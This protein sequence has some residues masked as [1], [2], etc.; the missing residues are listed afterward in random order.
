MN[1]IAP[2]KHHFTSFHSSV[3]VSPK[4]PLEVLGGRFG[5]F[6]IELMAGGEAA[7]ARDAQHPRGASHLP[8]LYSHISINEEPYKLPATL[9]IS[10]L[11]PFS[12]FLKNTDKTNIL[13]ANNK[14]TAHV[15][16][17]SVRLMCGKYGLDKVGFLTLTFAD[18]ILDPMEAQ[19]RLNS[20]L[21][22]IIKPR[23]QDYLGVMERQKSGRIHYHFLVALDV[24]IRTG[25]N[26]D[27]ASNGVYKSASNYLR[28]EWAF[29]RGTSK[30][31]GFGR[32]ELM[33]IKSSTEAIG[34]YVGKYISKHIECRNQE[35]RGVR[36]VRYSRGARAGTTKFQFNT[37]GSAQW[38]EKIKQFAVMVSDFKKVDVNNISDLSKVLG[39]RWAF[40]HRELIMALP[41]NMPNLRFISR[42]CR[43]DGD[44][45]YVELPITHHPT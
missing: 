23:Y 6:N 8:C 39:V 16:Y 24:D 30:A 4:S 44:L 3:N 15:L 1:I 36:L 33:P 42:N 28:S 7:T 31:Y 20:L 25:F 38:R 37:I 43:G 32:T 17:E 5:L 2:V 22:N 19:R 35:D 13:S 12:A 21:T 26:F 45:G 29:W 10:S 40:H 18:H 34:R 41:T 9:D 14:R 27:Q 11:D